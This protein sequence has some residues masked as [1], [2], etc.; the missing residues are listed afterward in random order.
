MSFFSSRRLQT[1]LALDAFFFLILCVAMTRGGFSSGAALKIAALL[2]LANA[3]VVLIAGAILIFPAL[4]DSPADEKKFGA[5]LARHTGLTEE[6]RSTVL[7]SIRAESDALRQRAHLG[8]MVVV[9]GAMFLI[10]AFGTA[11][12]TITRLLPSE[13]V[14]ANSSGPVVNASITREQ[15][16]RFTGDQV[17]GALFLDI[18]EL[19]HWYLSGL[20]NNRNAPAFTTF[21]FAFRA[22]VGWASLVTMITLARSFRL[23]RKSVAKHARSVPAKTP[24]QALAASAPSG[25]DIASRSMAE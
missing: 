23:R 10:L 21:T 17:S 7:E 4:L 14:F 9:T 24:A 1:C 16:W 22:V 18:P 13:S 20:V 25:F 19:Y 11:T 3:V 8:R 6:L 12:S 5:L 15:A 2:L